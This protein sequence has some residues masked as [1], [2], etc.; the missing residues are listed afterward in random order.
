MKAWLAAKHIRDLEPVSLFTEQLEKVISLDV[1]GNLY[2]LTALVA[3]DCGDRKV[4][5]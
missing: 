4:C 3:N 2:A 5:G 1:D